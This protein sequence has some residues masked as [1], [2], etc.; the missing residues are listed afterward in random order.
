MNCSIAVLCGVFAQSSDALSADEIK[1][2][3]MTTVISGDTPV[4]E[5]D[6]LPD[7]SDILEPSAEARTLPGIQDAQDVPETVE[8]VPAD[9]G[10]GK[11]DI[12][13][14]GLVGAGYSNVFIGDFTV[15]KATGENPFKLH[16]GHDS[17]SG[18]ARNDVSDNFEDSKT[19]IFGEK[20][21]T[22]GI[23]TWNVF[24]GYDRITDGLQLVSP[25][26]ED[27]TKQKVHGGF[28][29]DSFFN[30]GI[31][32][33][34]GVDTSWYN[35]YNSLM[36]NAPAYT[37]AEEGHSIISSNPMARFSWSS[38]ALTVGVEGKYT[39]H[40]N[41][42]DSDAMMFG[43]QTTHRGEA[44]TDIGWHNDI[45][46]VYEKAGIVAGTK[47]GDQSL[48]V[49]FTV[50]GSV[51]FHTPLSDRAVELAAE[52]G[53]QTSQP[54]ISDLETLYA[55]TYMA[56]IPGE[57]SD[58]YGKETLSLPIADV[59]TL[60]QTGEYRKTAFD[61]GV[62]QPIYASTGVVSK[63]YGY[64]QKEMTRF[65]TV[66]AASVLMGPMT[67]TVDWTAQWIDV[68]VLEYENTIGISAS[69]QD[70]TATYGGEVHVRF[71]LDSDADEVPNIG[72]ETFYRMNQSVRLAA[73]VDD[74]VKLV[75][76]KSRTYAGDYIQRSGTAAVVVKFFF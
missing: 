22:T 49:P 25:V 58:W 43:K 52:G 74:I 53:M 15:Y 69:L 18:Y 57:T 7:F 36:Y 31:E 20:T 68:P 8:S 50:G 2:P 65:K 1:L 62:W 70:S 41:A 27:M 63:L 64:T 60:S 37:A 73:Q 12:F 71:D 28:T 76:G 51:R 54:T 72:G 67:A 23:T 39:V 13:V 33:L 30:N 59:L 56:G 10:A 47:I 44:F 24:G 4:A 35:R 75:T 21:I 46:S 66:S 38:D 42:G 32:F 9:T 5:K 61:N 19:T 48:L 55:F 45:F 40:S 3:E 6:V 11:K 14:E 29:S 34:F 26:F 17:A 16:F